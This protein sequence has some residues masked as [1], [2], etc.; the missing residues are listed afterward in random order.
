MNQVSLNG[1]NCC[2]EI[3]FLDIVVHINNLKGHTLLAKLD[4]VVFTRYLLLE[5]LFH[6]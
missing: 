2:D 6:C 4:L 3:G 5:G 1:P